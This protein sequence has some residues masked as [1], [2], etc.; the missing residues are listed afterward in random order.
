MTDRNENIIAATVS[1][2][3][4]TLIAAMLYLYFFAN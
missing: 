4:L 3:V 1:I 2:A